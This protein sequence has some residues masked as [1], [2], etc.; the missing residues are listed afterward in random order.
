MV[1]AL[2]GHDSKAMSAHYPHVGKEALANGGA[3]AARDLSGLK[4]PE[5]RAPSSWP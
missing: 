3:V 2:V 5:L 4:N 1:M